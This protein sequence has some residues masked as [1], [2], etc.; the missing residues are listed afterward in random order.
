MEQ[1]NIRKLDEDSFELVIV[2]TTSKQLRGRPARAFANLEFNFTL[3]GAK[4]V[5]GQAVSVNCVEVTEKL[6]ETAQEV[7]AEF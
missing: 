4:S 6:Q 3:Q 5:T 2:P 7:I 1:L